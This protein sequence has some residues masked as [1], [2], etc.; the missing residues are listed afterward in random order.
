MAGGIQV[1]IKN[2]SD[3]VAA[4][5]AGRRLASDAG[6]AGSE[7]TVIVTAV[8]ELARNIVRYAKEG[9]ISF[10]ILDNPDHK[11]IE[12]TAS[13]QGP[14]IP[15]TALTLEDGYSTSNG[16]GLGLPGVRRLMDEFAIESRIGKGTKIITKKWMT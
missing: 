12:I 10:Q 15:N 16:L 13:D 4:R 7:L 1:S 2:D 11:G 14:G 3:I 8:S 5:T 6:F 9:E